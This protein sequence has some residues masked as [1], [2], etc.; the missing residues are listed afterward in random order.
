MSNA[1][2]EIIIEGEATAHKTAMNEICRDNTKS[3]LSNKENHYIPT[4]TSYTM[5]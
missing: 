2:I 5:W 3:L 1:H 4:S